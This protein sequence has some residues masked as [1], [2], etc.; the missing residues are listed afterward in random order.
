[1]S[2]RLQEVSSEKV[3]SIREEGGEA[4]RERQRHGH[5]RSKAKLR[6]R[7]RVVGSVRAGRRQLEE[8]CTCPVPPS[9]PARASV[10]YRLQRGASKMPRRNVRVNGNA[11]AVPQR[12]APARAKRAR[13]SVVYEYTCAPLCLC[14]LS[15]ARDCSTDTA[16][17]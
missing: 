15:R 7:D 1:M 10:V 12:G 9:C 11:R 14:A 8:A 17:V 4:G 2:V 16:F 5:D 13:T 3:E 6:C